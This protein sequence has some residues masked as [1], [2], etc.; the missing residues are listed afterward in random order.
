MVHVIA[1]D[2]GLEVAQPFAKRP[3]D[4]WQPLGTEHDQRDHED[5]QKMRWLKDVA[6]HDLQ[7]RDLRQAG[8]E[9]NALA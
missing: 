2:G 3:A 6:D 9:V 4:F 5:E 1:V 8:R 7:L